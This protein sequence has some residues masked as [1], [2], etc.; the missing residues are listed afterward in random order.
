MRQIPAIRTRPATPADAAAIAEI[1]NQGI[2]E[3]VATF[4]TEPRTPAQIAAWLE[5]GNL[6]IVAAAEGRGPVAFAASFPYSPRPC[7]AGIGEFSVY[8]APD[9]RGG[10]VGK[11]ALAIAARKGHRN[12]KRLRRDYRSEESKCRNNFSVSF[13]HRQRGAST[14]LRSALMT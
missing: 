10:G 9:F 5:P 14:T 13:S 1:Y 7:Y 2:A 4:E 3:R 12:G 8:V 11:A 6:V